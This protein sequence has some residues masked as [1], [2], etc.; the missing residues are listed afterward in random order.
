MVSDDVAFAIAMFTM[1]IGVVLGI[2]FHWFLFS[3]EVPMSSLEYAINTCGSK[4][5]VQK[6]YIGH[7]KIKVDCVD[8]A[9]YEE[10]LENLK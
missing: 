3:V 7:S 5:G 1:M 8:G 10:E 2:L 9:Y 4:G 6:L